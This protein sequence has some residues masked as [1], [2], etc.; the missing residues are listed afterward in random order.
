MRTTVPAALAASRPWLAAPVLLAGARR[1]AATPS[2]WRLNPSTVRA[3][4]EIAL[5]ASLRRQ[6]RS[7]HGHRDTDRRGHRRARVRL[8]DRDR[9]GA[10]R[11][12][13]PATTRS[14]CAARTA[15]PRAANLHVVAK[16]EPARGPA[17]GG[18]GTRPGRR[19]RC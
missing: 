2:S 4:D 7:R 17:T 9:D 1:A 18:G 3:G 19:R 13:R 6:P 10:G 12:P 16:V 5:R 11:P 14:P 15:R 8:P